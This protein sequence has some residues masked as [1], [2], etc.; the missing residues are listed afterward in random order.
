MDSEGLTIDEV[1]AR[2]G[3][4]PR[5]VHYYVAQ[6]LLHGPGKQ[7]PRTRYSPAFLDL[8]L[9][10]RML[11]SERD[12]SLRSIRHLFEREGVIAPRARRRRPSPRTATDARST[13][14][15]N[16]SSDEESQAR[17][18]RSDRSD[19][20]GVPQTPPELARSMGASQRVD[21][22]SGADAAVGM[23]P[24]IEPRESQ[25]ADE[26]SGADA[27][28]GGDLLAGS[29]TA[30][31]LLQALQELVGERRVPSAGSGDRWVTIPISRD[32]VLA[33]RR[34]RPDDLQALQRAADHLRFILLNGKRA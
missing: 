15:E 12:L 23:W 10:I 14:T 30:A 24:A 9:R 34:L 3:V 26:T 32:L 1:A 13:D 18:S 5:T 2:A 11:Q 7:G 31:D 20:P 16:Q 21:D 8:L 28:G 22:E 6:G 27:G 33:G 17:S 25:G 4:T 19:F 29:P